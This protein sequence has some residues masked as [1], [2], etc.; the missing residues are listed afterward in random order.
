[1]KLINTDIAESVIVR[2]KKKLFKLMTTTICFQETS[3]QYSG[4][5][6]RL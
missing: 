4:M 2:G 3:I 1:M 6:T 5:A